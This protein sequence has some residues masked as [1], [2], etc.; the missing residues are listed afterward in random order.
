MPGR[1]HHQE[2]Q[3]DSGEGRALLNESPRAPNRVAPKWRRASER[4]E[5]PLTAWH[6]AV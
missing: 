3:D 6:R 2:S 4:S 1:G 5:E